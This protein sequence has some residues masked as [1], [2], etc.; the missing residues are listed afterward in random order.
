MDATGTG[1]Q[2]PGSAYLPITAF[3]AAHQADEVTCTFAE[4]EQILGRPLPRYAFT[5]AWWSRG[6]ERRYP[7]P[8]EGAGWRVQRI[9]IRQRWV[10]FARQQTDASAPHA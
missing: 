6:H 7:Q 1:K 9:K 10:T 2:H 5:Y 8:W 3:L 4:I